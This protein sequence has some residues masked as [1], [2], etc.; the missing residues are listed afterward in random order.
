[1]GI[2]SYCI[3]ELGCDNAERCRNRQEFPIQYVGKTRSECFHDARDDGW[4]LR[5]R[6]GGSLCPAC[7]GKERSPKKVAD[8]GHPFGGAHAVKGESITRFLAFVELGKR[9]AGSIERKA[10]E[11]EGD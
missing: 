5:T 1:M 7:S 2:A 9:H 10:H 8:E 6:S 11:K 4:L 3:V